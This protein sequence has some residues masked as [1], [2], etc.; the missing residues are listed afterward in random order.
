VNRQGSG[1]PGARRRAGYRSLPLWLQWVLPFSV[2]GALVL[3][4]VLFVNYE[5]NDVPATAGYNSPAAVAEQNR[6]DTI[7]VR[8]QQAPHHARL[9]AG[10][11]AAGGLRRAVLAYMTR[12]IDQG[13]IDG[14]IEHASCRPAPG[15]ASTRLTFR[16]EVTAS[17][18]MV[19]YPF[20]GVVQPSARAITYCQRVTP[21][22]PSMNVPVSG[23]CT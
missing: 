6:E 13:T 20:D 22:V 9:L 11:P 5:T 21:P 18:Q 7:L 8:E 14:P 3:A 12:Q 16:C 1:L 15:T 4:V 19:T 23:R 2:A 10:Q 17:A